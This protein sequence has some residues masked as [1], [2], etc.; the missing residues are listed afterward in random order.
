MS[1][2]SP[3]TKQI[4]EARFEAVKVVLAVAERVLLSEYERNIVIQSALLAAKGLQEE[5]QRE[6]GAAE[7]P[8][9]ADESADESAE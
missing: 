1:N 8:E 4:L 2:Q 7:A 5:Y 6:V 3:S 9:S